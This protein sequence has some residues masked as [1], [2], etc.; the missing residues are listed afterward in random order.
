PDFLSMFLD[1][2]RLAGRIRHPNVVSVFD[3]VSRQGELFLI[4]DYVPGETLARLARAA[5]AQSERVPLPVALAVLAG[6]LDG[7]H[8]AHEASDESGA[9]LSI[10]HRDVSPQNILVG[11]D[12]TARVLDFGVAKAVGRM[13]VTRG[14][15]LK[16][17]LA[18][19]APEQLVRGPLDRGTDI[20]AAS[21]VLWELL[22]RRRLFQGEDEVSTFKLALEAAIRAPSQVLPELPQMLDAIV[23]K[24]LARNRQERFSTAREMARALEAT[25]LLA[26]DR[27]VADWVE[28]V[29]RKPLAAR[30][31]RLADVERGFSSAAGP[32]ELDPEQARS[33]A[34][35][36]RKI[37]RRGAAEAATVIVE[38]PADAGER[39]SALPARAS[40]AA[41]L[42]HGAPLAAEIGT[43]LAAARFEGLR[44]GFVFACL[45]LGS[46]LLLLRSFGRDAS[47]PIPQAALP[48]PRRLLP[49]TAPPS[50]LP[51]KPTDDEL[52]VATSTVPPPPSAESVLAQQKPRPVPPF[53]QAQRKPAKSRTDCFVPFTVDAQGFRIP[54]RQCL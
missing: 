19:M 2:A 26:S 44:L 5:S 14:D 22:T 15:E 8:A 20:Y 17:K 3:V 18:Y 53:G 21:I 6:V 43:P 11:T 27:E 51:P 29:A 4:M 31:R 40:N 49:S 45:V 41:P 42:Q 47:S 38:T 30:A 34:S 7:L 23:L 13:Q 25:G 48:P 35:L 32:R 1:E 10:V 12:G 52:A 54:K 50:P 46:A 36:L 9:P 39:S 24:G 16:G 33:D 28:R 37:D